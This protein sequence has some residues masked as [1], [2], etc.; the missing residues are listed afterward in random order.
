MSL[1]LCFLFLFGIKILNF[2]SLLL[3]F[4][5]PSL[6]MNRLFSSPSPSKKGFIV[7]NYIYSKINSN[8]I[9][10]AYFKP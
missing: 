4:R 3:E 1:I 7:V 8:K 2:F 6:S 5:S 9:P 10:K